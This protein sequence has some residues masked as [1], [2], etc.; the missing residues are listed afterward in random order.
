MSLPGFDANREVIPCLTT[1]IMSEEQAADGVQ[2][3]PAHF[4]HV[5]HDFPDGCVGNG[6]VD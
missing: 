6:H 2:D 1:E 4:H 5:L 3:A